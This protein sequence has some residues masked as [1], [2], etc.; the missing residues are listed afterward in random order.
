MIQTKKALVASLMFPI[1]ALAILTAYK[2]YVLSF[3]EE[4]ILPISGYDPRDLLSGHYLIYRIDYGVDGICSASLDQ[5]IGYVCLEP[6]MFSYSTPQ[7]CSKLIRG[8]CKSGQFE[9]GIEKYY[10]PED[11]A[12]DLEVQIRA[13]KASI[14]LSVTHSGQ[15]QVKDLLVNGQ[16]WKNP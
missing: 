12:S 10:V 7:G 11:K 16:S 3:G 4:I 1:L 15:A 14:V 13:N 6:K 2:K 5:Q 9:A 8:V